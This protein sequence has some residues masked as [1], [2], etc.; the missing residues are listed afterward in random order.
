MA[1][2]RDCSGVSLR[3]SDSRDGIERYL[4]RNPGLSFVALDGDRVVGTILAGH[5]SRRGYIQHL[6]VADRWR[7]RGI[8]TG[9]LATCLDALKAVGIDKSH[10]HVLADNR[11][12]RQFWSARGWHHRAEI[13]MYSFVNGDN[14]NV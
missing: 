11:P 6:A 4:A 5:D 2:W 12:G 8:A 13:A 14:P 3:D 7:K 10:V 1:L 9:L